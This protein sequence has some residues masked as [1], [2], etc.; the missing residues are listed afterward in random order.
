[1]PDPVTF[2][3]KTVPASNL[4]SD[5][6]LSDVPLYLDVYPPDSH[7]NGT[8]ASEDDSAGVPAVVYFHGG[9]LLVGDRKSWFPE[10]LHSECFSVPSIRLRPLTGVLFGQDAYLNKAWLSSRRTTDSYYLPP[11]TKS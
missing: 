4:T 10:W 11:D 6:G 2:T 5:G 8:S 1:M 9:G 3:Y 7:L